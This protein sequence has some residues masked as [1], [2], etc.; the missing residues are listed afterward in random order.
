MTNVE[1]KAILDAAVVRAYTAVAATPGERMDSADFAQLL[2]NLNE[3]QY[4]SL[5]FAIGD[6]GDAPSLTV[7][8]QPVDLREEVGNIGMPGITSAAE[9]KEIFPDPAPF[10]EPAAEEPT[11]S[12]D[13]LRT[14]ISSLADKYDTLDVA[15]IMAG[16]GYEKLSAIPKER[17]GELLRLVGEAVR[18]VG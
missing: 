16:M 14:R 8:S 11:L 2:V 4:A 1:K 12:L 15:S 13:E 7:D 3:L 6:V 17:Y 5:R 10:P 18:E 9:V